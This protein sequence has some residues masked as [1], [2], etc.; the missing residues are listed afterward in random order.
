MQSNKVIRTAK[1]VVKDRKEMFEALMEF[2]RT[3]KIKTKMRLNF[4]IDK[5][6]ASRFRKFCKSKRYNMSAKIEEAMENIMK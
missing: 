4:T 2:E 5:D 3:N 1:K 6:L